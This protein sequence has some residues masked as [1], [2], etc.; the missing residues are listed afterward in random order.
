MAPLVVVSVVVLVAPGALLPVVPVRSCPVVPLPGVRVLLAPVVPVPVVPVALVP[1]VPVRSCPVVLEPVVPLLIE[2][3]PVVPLLLDVL[4]PVVP[5]AVLAGVP[6]PCVS[7]GS[8][9]LVLPPAEAPV[10][11]CANAR[12]AAMAR[13]TEVA[14]SVCFFMKFSVR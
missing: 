9:L 4:L 13:A 5:P 8:V 7:L 2:L 12:P 3:L 10:P 1:A 14:T 11:A 6:G